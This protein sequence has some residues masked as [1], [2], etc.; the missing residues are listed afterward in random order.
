MYDLVGSFT[1]TATYLKRLICSNIKYVDVELFFRK[2]FRSSSLRVESTTEEIIF[3]TVGSKSN[4]IQNLI[5]VRDETF[6]V[7]VSP[8]AWFPQLLL[9]SSQFEVIHSQC[10]VTF[11]FRISWNF[12]WG[13][14]V[15]LCSQSDGLTTF[16]K[17]I[18]E[19]VPDWGNENWIK[20]YILLTSIIFKYLMFSSLFS[21]APNWN[22]SDMLIAEVRNFKQRDWIKKSQKIRNMVPLVHS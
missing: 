20:N 4:V 16:P 1:T 2:R 15:L 8:L 6:T 21:Q 17:L 14:P 12:F 5:K 10:E 9:V 22:S 7:T 19:S 11:G 13:S 3:Q 18:R